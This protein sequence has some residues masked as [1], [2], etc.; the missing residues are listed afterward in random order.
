MLLAL[1]A[2]SPAFGNRWCSATQPYLL[3][4]APAV[5]P[6]RCRAHS[7]S[8]RRSCERYCFCPRLCRGCGQNWCCPDPRRGHLRRRQGYLSS[9]LCRSRRLCWRRRLYVSLG[10]SRFGRAGSIAI[11]GT[12]VLRPGCFQ[13]LPGPFA[14]SS[15][16]APAVPDFPSP[17]PADELPSALPPLPWPWE[18][19]PA[20]LLPALA[21]GLVPPPAPPAWTTGVCRRFGRPGQGCLCPRLDRY[22]ALPP[23]LPAPGL[24]APALPPPGC[25]QPGCLQAEPPL[26]PPAFR[27]RRLRFRRRRTCHRYLFRRCFHRHR[28]CYSRCFSRPHCRRHRGLRRDRHRGLRP[29]A[30]ASSTPIA[31]GAVTALGQGCAIQDGQAGAMTEVKL[32][33]KGKS[34]S[35]ACYRDEDMSPPTCHDHLMTASNARLRKLQRGEVMNRGRPV[36]AQHGTLKVQP[37][38][39]PR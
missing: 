24:P 20:L 2:L 25:L 22:R 8:Y 36:G 19:P 38:T 6:V 14:A 1:V 7:S 5:L 9:S 11:S 29:I 15:F 35:G 27:P 33:P 31:P 37:P 17:E 23:W 18:L 32:N 12:P 28:L 34:S 13:P 16:A 4:S 26:L 39:N 21:P 3:D 10:G 30:A